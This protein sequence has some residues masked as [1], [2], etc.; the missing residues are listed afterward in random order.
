M[1]PVN[2]ADCRVF[3]FSSIQNERNLSERQFLSV[4]EICALLISL[5]KLAEVAAVY[6]VRKK[7]HII[8]SGQIN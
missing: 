4:R 7:S 1:P 5:Q 3:F 2:P 6:C 8:I